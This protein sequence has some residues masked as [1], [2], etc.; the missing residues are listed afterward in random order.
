MK[1]LKKIKD[2]IRKLLALSESPNKAEAASA[3]AKANLLLSQE[4]L[5]VGDL[6]SVASNVRNVLLRETDNL[7][8][9]EERLLKCITK[10]TATDALKIY[11]GDKIHIRIIG[12]EPN[13]I[14]A[15]NYYEYLQK[16]VEEKSELFNES[17]G[18]IESFRIGMVEGINQQIQQKKEVKSALSSSKDVIRNT[19]AEYKKDNDQY[20]ASEYGNSNISDNWYTVEPNSFHLGKSI[21]RKI[22]IYDQIDMRVEAGRREK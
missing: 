12:R 14:S 20:I 18:D 15:I 22:S 10:A 7:T 11:N 16:T 13:T 8:P 19:A 6:S 4:G 5:S 17:I 3:L 2:R 21:G 1:S 9:W